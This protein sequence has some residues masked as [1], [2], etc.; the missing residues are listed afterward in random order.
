MKKHQTIFFVFAVVPFLISGII[1]HD[2]EKEEYLE[3]ANKK[4]FDCIGQ[5]QINPEQTGSAVL[6]NKNYILTAA[7]ILIE[8]DIR[9][10]T[11]DN[12][13]MIFYANVPINHRV[14]PLDSVK[15]CINEIEYPISKIVIHPNY[16]KDF[17][18]GENDIAIIK[19][20]NPI[21]D[22]K[23]AKLNDQKDELNS[24]VI[25]VGYGG[26]GIGNKDGLTFANEKI[27]GQNVVD[28]IGGQKINGLY[29]FLYCDFDQPN[30]SDSN[31]M[32]SPEPLDLEYLCGAGDSGGGLFK[33]S[34]Q[35]W[36]LVGICKGYEFDH[37][38]FQ[39]TKH[40]GQIMRWTRVLPYEEWI[41]KNCL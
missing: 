26:F 2:R 13:G 16:L 39:K 11:V 12:N 22:I 19:L 35:D 28:S 18:T 9:V 15:F 1:R 31:K 8:N 27:A 6:I 41:N 17:D 5:I 33:K 40:Y 24:K 29:N 32:G 30:T 23:P 7:H 34:G 3:L 4:Q 21:S 10:D 20:A 14:T 36:T 37:R 38:Q 25:G